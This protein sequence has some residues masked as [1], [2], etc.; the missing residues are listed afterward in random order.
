MTAG[1]ELAWWRLAFA[2]ALLGAVLLVLF[3]WRLGTGVPSLWSLVH[4]WLEQG[5]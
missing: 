4:G 5:G 2:L 3:V 1:P